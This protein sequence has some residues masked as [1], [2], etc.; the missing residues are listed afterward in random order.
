MFRS[1]N[2]DLTIYALYQLDV[3]RNDEIGRV[4][5]VGHTAVTAA[6]NRARNYLEEDSRLEKVIKEILN[7]K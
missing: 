3:H 6:V 2:R 7:D 4:F 1:M 5:G